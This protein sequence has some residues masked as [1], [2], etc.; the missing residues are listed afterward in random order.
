MAAFGDCTAG[1][2]YALAIG[3]ASNSLAPSRAEHHIETIIEASPNHCKFGAITLELIANGQAVFRPDGGWLFLAAP[4]KSHQK[5][6]APRLRGR[7]FTG[8]TASD[9]TRLSK[10]LR[11]V[12]VLPS[13]SSSSTG[14]TPRVLLRYAQG[15]TGKR[16]ST[17]RAPQGRVAQPPLQPS[18]AEHPA[19]PGDAAGATSSWVLL[20]GKT[21]RSTSPSGRN[22]AFPQQTNIKKP[23]RRMAFFRGWRDGQPILNASDSDFELSATLI[24]CW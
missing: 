4:R 14:R 8:G 6:G 12:L 7:R 9:L 3:S 15:A 13:A 19:Q 11:S 24:G 18:S 16:A 17:V 22:T 1:R 23:S 10:K 2:L 20:L 5:E 21:R